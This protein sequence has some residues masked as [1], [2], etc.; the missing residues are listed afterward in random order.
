[1]SSFVFLSSALPREAA[2]ARAENLL[3]VSGMSLRSFLTFSEMHLVIAG[4]YFVILVRSF[5]ER[6]R[7]AAVIAI[8]RP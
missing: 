2:L 3:I 1:M 5:V 7:N 6:G 8:P 4:K